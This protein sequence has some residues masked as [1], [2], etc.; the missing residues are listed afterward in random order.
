MSGAVNRVIAPAGALL[1]I[2]YLIAMVASGA[3]PERR[4]FIEFQANGV[5]QMDPLGIT[6]VELAAEEG[7]Q[8]FERSDSGWIMPESGTELEKQAALTLDRAVK[9][10]HTAAPARAFP[11]AELPADAFSEFGLD[12]P[13]L[14]VVLATPSGVALEVDFGDSSA[15]GILQYMHVEGS[16][17]VHMISRFVSAEWLAVGEAAPR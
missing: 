6:R 3:L 1:A 4:N 11:L 15:D 10:M 17:V 12:R 5:L 2:L 7:S 13:T 9:F 16:D 8:V 14:S